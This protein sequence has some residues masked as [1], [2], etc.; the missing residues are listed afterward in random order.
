M[1]ASLDWSVRDTRLSPSHSH[2]TA[3]PGLSQDRPDLCRRS[4]NKEQQ[5][6]LTSHYNHCLTDWLTVGAKIKLSS[7]DWVG[8][9][10]LF[11]KDCW[12][13]ELNCSVVTVPVWLRRDYVTL[14]CNVN[15]ISRT[16]MVGCVCIYL[17]FSLIFHL[18]VRVILHSMQTSRWILCPQSGK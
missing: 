18:V 3:V 1:L 15:K 2:Q 11:C 16:R 13:T 4:E 14:C 8:I 10:F 12:L 7:D 6:T 9:Q 5:I 17:Y